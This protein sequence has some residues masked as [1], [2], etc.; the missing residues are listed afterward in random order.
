[1]FVYGGGLRRP[2]TFIEYAKGLI[3]KQHAWHIPGAEPDE[4]TRSIA[5]MHVYDSIIVFDKGVVTRPT[6][7]R[8]GKRSF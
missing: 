1:M 5:G 3:D 8:T 7:P 2:G 4:Y 6:D